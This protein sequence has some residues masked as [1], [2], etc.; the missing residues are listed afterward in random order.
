DGNLLVID[1]AT[2]PHMLIAGA[3]RTGKSVALNTALLSLMSTSPLLELI[4]I[5]PKQVELAAYNTSR[6]C[7]E[8]VI[9]DMTA[10]AERLAEVIDIMERRYSL[11]AAVGVKNIAGYNKVST[12][13]LPYIVVVID[14]FAD[15]IMMAG[16]EVEEL[17]AR[18]GQKA[19]AA[20]IHLII[21]TQRP[22]A[23]VITGVIKANIMTRIAFKVAG[24][25]NSE[26]IIGQSGAENLLGHGDGLAQIKDSATPLRFHGAFCP[27]DD[28]T[29][30]VI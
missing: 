27:D 21:A 16:K 25:I 14:E 20:G 17:I 26:I 7:R 15:M 4:L 5:D 2:Q 9:T 19:R 1:L 23:D 29:K 24:R 18:L 12:D 8:A 30:W 3:T 22:S 13:K 6:F 11:M 10:A 28:I